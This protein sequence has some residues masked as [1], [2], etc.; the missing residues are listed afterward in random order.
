MGNFF[1]EV[2]TVGLKAVN[3]GGN[4]ID[5]L[6][7]CMRL[8]QRRVFKGASVVLV[9]ASLTPRRATQRPLG[10]PWRRRSL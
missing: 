5:N 9:E 3:S 6:K 10:R 8:N 1:D 4:D 2:K 7:L